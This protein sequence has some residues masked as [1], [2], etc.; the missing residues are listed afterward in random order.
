MYFIS[1]NFSFDDIDSKSMGVELVTFGDSFFNQMGTTY[2]E[3]VD[4]EG[5][6]LKLPLYT[7]SQEINTEDITLNLLLVNKDGT[8]A[9]WDDM[10]TTEIMDWLITDGFKPF[11]SED[12]LDV[13][14]YFKVVK[15]VKK[16]TVDRTGYL[17]VTFKPYSNYTYHRVRQSGNN[18]IVVNN[19]SNVDSHYKPILEI[20]S[21]SSKVTIT[22]ESISNSP[23]LEIVGVTGKILVD[24]LFRTVQSE[25]GKNL[26]SKCNRKWM[27]LKKG[28][29]T[30]SVSGGDVTVVCEFPMIR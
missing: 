9:T 19:T 4:L 29:N 7:K 22:N 14:Y 27:E 3:S 5:T 25:D 13:T 26:L 18:K 17:E 24:N 16:F 20:E 12:D 10:K 2:S 23:T 28:V 21:N 8:Q 15:I 1:E 11:V 6:F 30:I